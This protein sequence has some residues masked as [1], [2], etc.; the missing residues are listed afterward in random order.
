VFVSFQL[1]SSVCVCLPVCHVL[2]CVVHTMHACM[3][4]CVC[5]SSASPLLSCPFADKGSRVFDTRVTISPSRAAWP[6]LLAVLTVLQTFLPIVV[7]HTHTSEPLL[8]KPGNE[9]PAHT[10]RC[11]N[12]AAHG[13]P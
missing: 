7:R 12:R 2:C 9:A 5:N 13:W 8:R 3:L 10:A 6:M 11:T 1:S 4:C